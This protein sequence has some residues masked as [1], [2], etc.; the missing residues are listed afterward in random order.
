MKETCENC[1]F[2][3]LNEQC[4]RH[5]PRVVL[6]ERRCMTTVF[7]CTGGNQ[8][9]GEW[10][11][12]KDPGAVTEKKMDPDSGF[13]TCK[14]C[15]SCRHKAGSRCYL[16][17]VGAAKDS[18]WCYGWEGAEDPEPDEAVSDHVVTCKK[19]NI[20]WTYPGR[21][22]LD[23]RVCGRCRAER[24]AV[25][26]GLPARATGDGHH[27]NRCGYKKLAAERTRREA[28]VSELRAAIYFALDRGHSNRKAATA[29]NPVIPF[30]Y[31]WQEN[32][33]EFARLAKA[34]GVEVSGHE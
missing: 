32:W 3:R 25:C 12:S 22:P 24:C 11:P 1:R 27:C 17:P 2:W 6:N 10:E 20:Q 13:G 5:S 8:W 7:P 14:T 9:C 33:T 15:K 34:A 29:A 19:C 23:D 21:L 16:C 28:L 30:M 31:L 18:Y 26:G 4:C